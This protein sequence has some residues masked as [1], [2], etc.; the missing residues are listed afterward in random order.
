MLKENA[1]FVGMES[2]IRQ[3]KNAMMVICK[4]KMA[5]ILNVPSSLLLS[6]KMDHP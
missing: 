5:V 6:A 4:I 2:E 1:I 3:A